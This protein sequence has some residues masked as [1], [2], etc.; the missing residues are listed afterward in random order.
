MTP[1]ALRLDEF[2][3]AVHAFYADPTKNVD[4]YLAASRAIGNPPTGRRRRVL[5]TAT[6]I[7]DGRS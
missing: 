3:D 1:P 2:R 4:R 6:E 5:E 7:S